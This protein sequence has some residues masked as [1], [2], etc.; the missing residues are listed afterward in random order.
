MKTR[1]GKRL[2]QVAVDGIISD[3][4]VVVDATLR[5]VE[6]NVLK[7]VTLTAEQQEELKSV[8]SDESITNPFQ[9]LETQ[10]KQ[11]SFIQENFNFVVIIII[12]LSIPYYDIIRCLQREFWEEAL[13]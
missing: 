9:G 4:K 10:Y 5:Y 13:R 8:F 3:T 6:R 1:D 12:I 2:T 11:Q 7:K